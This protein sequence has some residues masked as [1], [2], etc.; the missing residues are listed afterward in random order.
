MYMH[1]LYLLCG[2]RSDL[3]FTIFGFFVLFVCWYNNLKKVM[4][5][6]FLLNYW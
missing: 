6:V 5:D 1:I 4:M 2:K 3:I